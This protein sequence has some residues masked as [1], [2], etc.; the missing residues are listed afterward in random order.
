MYSIEELFNIT[1]WMCTTV[2]VY[3]SGVGGAPGLNCMI[4]CLSL[5]YVRG[6]VCARALLKR[7]LIL[8]DG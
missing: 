4:A 3:M 5:I 6:R 7:Y 2:S 8:P 1:R